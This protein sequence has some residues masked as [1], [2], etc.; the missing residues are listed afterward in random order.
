MIERITSIVG[1]SRC[2]DNLEIESSY[3]K[4]ACYV[5]AAKPGI[6]VMS[7]VFTCNPS[8]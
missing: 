5:T 2:N 7:F 8:Y 1:A 6:I 3:G 4:D